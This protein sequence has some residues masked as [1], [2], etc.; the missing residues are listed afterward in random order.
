MAGH[1]KWANIKHKKARADAQK[2]H[3]FTKISREL[4]VA[5]RQGGG[6]IDSNFRLRLAVQKARDVNMPNDNI[7]RAIKKGLGEVD[8]MKFEEMIYEGYGPGGVAILLEIMTDNR[9][10]TASE[11]RNIFTRHNG[12]LGETGCVAWM[13][14]RRGYISLSKDKVDID[15]DD[16]MLLVLEEG[17]EDFKTEGSS[18]E[19]ITEPE[20]LEEVKNSLLNRQFDVDIAEVTMF[21]QSVV[22]VDDEEEGKVLLQLMESLEDHD[23][24]QSVYA[25][26]DV[27]DE[28]ISVGK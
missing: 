14:T 24:V 18:Y 6:D 26:F 7:N 17:A 15:E 3:L 12:N 20:L 28:I 4:M 25:N 16:L 2:G 21:P 23:D 10:R 22:K 13:F 9:N 11:L 19:I 1:S 8:G 5:A 27:S